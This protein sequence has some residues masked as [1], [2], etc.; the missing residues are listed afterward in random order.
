MTVVMVLISKPY[1][2][3][4]TT[5]AAATHCVM[6]NKVVSATSAQ[7][8]QT[9]LLVEHWCTNVYHKKASN[10]FGICVVISFTG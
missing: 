9:C 5:N 1:C 4:G 8:V 6:Q 10:K 7:C 3:G 2:H